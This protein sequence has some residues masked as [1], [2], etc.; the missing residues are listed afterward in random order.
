MISVARN[1]QT[2]S[3]PLSV[4]PRM[5]REAS[6]TAACAMSLHSFDSAGEPPLA[7]GAI[8]WAVPTEGHSMDGGNGP[9]HDCYLHCRQV[10]HQQ[11]QKAR[12]VYQRRPQHLPGVY[13]LV[14]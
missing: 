1:S 10:K 3:L 9:P 4:G 6:E 11:S 7:E 13:V 5:L 14:E 2:A 12:Q 8:G